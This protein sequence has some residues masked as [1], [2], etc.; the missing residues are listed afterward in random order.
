MS[1]LIAQKRVDIKQLANLSTPEGS[2]YWMPVPHHV[3]IQEVIDQVERSKFELANDPEIGLSHEDARCFFLL[4][5]KSTH[6][7]FCLSIGGRNTHDKKFAMALFGGA[8]V[9]ICSNL[10]AFG[11]YGMKTKHTTNVMDRLN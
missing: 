10:Q 11:Q 3:M 5:L 7:D 2:K 1:T 6:S 9:F 8:S 4:N